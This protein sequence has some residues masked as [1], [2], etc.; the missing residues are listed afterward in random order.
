MSTWLITPRCLRKGLLFIFQVDSFTAL[1]MILTIVTTIGFCPKY[2][3][4]VPY[5]YPGITSILHAPTPGLTPAPEATNQYKCFT[6]L[7]GS[8]LG[9]ASIHSH[10]GRSCVLEL[11]RN[12]DPMQL[13]WK[14]L[15]NIP[16][17]CW[18]AHIRFI[19]AGRSGYLFTHTE[20]PQ[21][22]CRLS[23]G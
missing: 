9:H 7:Q 21:V 12:S 17:L 5:P 23:S 18:Q 4:N 8:V 19:P 2:S 13:L 20:C 15:I 6:A 14:P 3:V 11:N 10:A 22:P 16:G 1:Y